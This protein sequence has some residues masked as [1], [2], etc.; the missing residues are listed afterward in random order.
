MMAVA[1]TAFS[2]MPDMISKAL[3]LFLVSI[4]NAT[5]DIFVNMAT[6]EAKKNDNLDKWLQISHGA[7]GIGGLIGP[8]LVYLFGEWSFASMSVVFLLTGPA[9]LFLKS[10]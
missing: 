5:I 7:F 10:P 6:I 8:I 1:L 3:L 9:Y 2:W 4:M